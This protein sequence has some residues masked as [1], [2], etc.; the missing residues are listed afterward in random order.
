MATFRA[1]ACFPF[2]ISRSQLKAWHTSLHVRTK[3]HHMWDCTVN[4]HHTQHT[5]QNTKVQVLG[6]TFHFPM[7]W[8]I[9]VCLS[10]SLFSPSAL[11]CTAWIF[12]AQS[13]ALTYCLDLSRGKTKARPSVWL[14]GAEPSII[15]CPLWQ[16][17]NYFVLSISLFKFRTNRHQCWA[18]L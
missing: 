17:L 4:V 8:H 11:W 2:Q 16:S 5:V 9:P 14:N 6:L 13:G 18:E 7:S 3:V 1:A 12:P 10:L 15:I